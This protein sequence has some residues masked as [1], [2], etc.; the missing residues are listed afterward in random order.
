MYDTFT[1]EDPFPP[2]PGRCDQAM[3]FPGMPTRFE[4][5]GD[6]GHRYPWHWY[7][8]SGVKVYWLSDVAPGSA[9]PPGAS[10]TEGDWAFG[11][12]EEPT[13]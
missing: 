7:E 3:S 13:L 1:M 9:D 5:V 12:A 6:S 8:D 2:L 11:S 4:C 10:P